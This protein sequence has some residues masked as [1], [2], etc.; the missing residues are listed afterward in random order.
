MSRRAWGIRPAGRFEA[1][2]EP[3]T[4]P[5]LETIRSEVQQ[6]SEIDVMDIPHGALPGSTLPLAGAPAAEAIYSA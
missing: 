1:E 6:P 5:G 2:P 4:A 3:S